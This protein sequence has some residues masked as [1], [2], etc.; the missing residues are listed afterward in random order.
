MLSRAQSANVGF[1]QVVQLFALAQKIPFINSENPNK[2]DVRIVR[3][4]VQPTLDPYAEA[5]I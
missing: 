3:A 5:F 2:T 1:S 4:G